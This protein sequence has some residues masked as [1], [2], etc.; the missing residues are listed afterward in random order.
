MFIGVPQELHPFLARASALQLRHS[1]VSGGREVSPTAMSPPQELHC[2][3][4]HDPQI[5]N[6]PRGSRIV[7]TAVPHQRHGR[8]YGRGTCDMSI[9]NCRA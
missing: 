6:G 4:L 7:D 1:R 5:A 2:P 9:L 8:L 3:L